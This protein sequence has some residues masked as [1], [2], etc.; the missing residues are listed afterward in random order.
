MY[1]YKYPEKW[2]L[3]TFVVFVLPA[4]FRNK[5]SF[6]CIFFAKKKKIEEFIKLDQFRL[7]S[8]KRVLEDAIKINTIIIS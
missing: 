3:L 6:K 8:S 2:K 7:N 1:I 5:C 4:L